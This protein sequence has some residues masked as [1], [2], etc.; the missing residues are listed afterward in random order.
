VQAPGKKAKQ[1]SYGDIPFH[2]SSFKTI[3]LTGI[4][5]ARQ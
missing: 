3:K 5:D 1:C 2:Y 4:R